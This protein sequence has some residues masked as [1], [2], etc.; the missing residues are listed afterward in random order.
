M[1]RGDDQPI[2]I[3]ER[4]N[5]QDGTI[6]HVSRHGGPVVIG[7]D[8]VVG[9]AA[10][11][12]SCRLEDGCLVGIGAVVLDGATVEAGAIVAAGAV[13]AP[14]EKGF[15]AGEMWGGMPARKLRDVHDKDR[16]YMKAAAAHYVAAAKAFKAERD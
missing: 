4:S 16:E 9:H 14:G 8:V 11:L 3:G 1:L 6:I 10:K 5:I 12:H 2:R 7:D 13:V 15:P